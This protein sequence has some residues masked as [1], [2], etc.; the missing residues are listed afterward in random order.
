MVFFFPLNFVLRAISVLKCAFCFHVIVFALLP[1][2]ILLLGKQGNTQRLD[3]RTIFHSGT[4]NT[5]CVIF[6]KLWGHERRN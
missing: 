2:L 1:L 6:L 4:I 3:S 5:R